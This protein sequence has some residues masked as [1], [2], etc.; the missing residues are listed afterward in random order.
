[1]ETHARH[2]QRCGL[3][4]ANGHIPCV[5]PDCP[6]L[7]NPGTVGYPIPPEL[8]TG[9]GLPKEP[10]GTAPHNLVAQRG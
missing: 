3:L 4:Q 9:S 10:L 6:H 1:M 2:C 7:R 8:L 5:D